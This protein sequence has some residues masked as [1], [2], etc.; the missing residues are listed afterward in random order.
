LPSDIYSSTVS[1]VLRASDIAA[2]KG[3]SSEEE[4]IEWDNNPHNT[5][6]NTSRLDSDEDEAAID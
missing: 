6:D 2:R 4:D 1:S 3:D 5:V